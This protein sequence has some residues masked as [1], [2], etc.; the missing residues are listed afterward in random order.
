MVICRTDR[1]RDRL[2]DR[3][4]PRSWAPSAIALVRI[5]L[6]DGSE[7]AGGRPRRLRRGQGRPGE[8]PVR[9]RRAARPD[10]CRT[11]PAG[12]GGG[13]AGPPGDQRRRRARPPCAGPTPAWSWPRRP[14]GPDGGGGPVARMRLGAALLIPPPVADEIDGLRR[15]FG[16]RSLGRV[17]PHLTLVP[18]VNVRRGRPGPGAG[19]A[20]GGGGDRRRPP[21]PSM[22]G[23]PATFLPANPV[24]LPGRRRPPTSSARARPPL[25]PLARARRAVRGPD[26]PSW[27]F[28]P[29][30]VDPGRPDRSPSPASRH[31][32]G[33][34]PGRASATTGRRWRSIGVHLLAGGPPDGDERRWVPLADA[35]FGPPGDHRPGRPGPRADPQPMLDPEA[36]APVDAAGADLV[37]PTAEGGPWRRAAGPD[38][39]WPRTARLV[40]TARREGRRRGW[41]A[42]PALGSRWRPGASVLVDARHRRQGIGSHVLAAVERRSAAGDWGCSR[43]GG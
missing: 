33:Q 23:P 25:A 7:T 22:L 6:A 35:A 30:H 36:A 17:P 37:G 41:S 1:R 18:P 9:R 29:P 28:A 10:R 4:T 40:V 27:P 5:K 15:A 3:V 16:D 26:R 21:A 32:A 12:Q 42:W 20:A 13:R 34:P 39:R 11:G 14:E 43:L 31:D 24:R 8:H 19:R 2:P 38:R